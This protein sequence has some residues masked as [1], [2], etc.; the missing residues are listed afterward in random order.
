MA[1]LY[2][3]TLQLHANNELELKERIKIFQIFNSKISLDNLKMLA[4]KCQDYD[5]EK[6]NK[7]IKTASTFF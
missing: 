5:H 6:I 4:V 2:T 1:Q 3:T 7:K